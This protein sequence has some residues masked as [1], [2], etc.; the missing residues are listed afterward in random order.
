MRDFG[1]T[2][3]ATKCV[4]MRQDA[5]DLG[6]KRLHVGE[7]HNAD[8]AAANLVFVSRADAT[9]CG[10]D[11]GAA[12]G[13]GVF[14]HAIQFTVQRQNERGIV[15]DTQV[16][17]GNLD[18]LRFQTADFGDQRMRVNDDTIAD[19]GELA[20]TH[21]AG[22]QK[23]KLVADTI[24]D[25]R[26]AGIVTALVPHDDICPLGQP[27]NNLAFAFVAPLRADHHNIRHFLL[28]CSWR[29]HAR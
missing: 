29:L 3:T 26:V 5:I 28:S 19:D 4:V 25:K 17:R 7:I 9:A 23:R 16:F 14:A 11:L 21:D 20:G 12:V 10:A 8:S 24:N 13:G 22:R 1:R 15:G 6:G 2:E 18:A 27:V